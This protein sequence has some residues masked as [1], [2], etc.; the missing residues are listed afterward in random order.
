MESYKHL[1]GLK[2]RCS[3]VDTL[4]NF[5]SEYSLEEHGEDGQ[6][7]E[8][9]IRSPLLVLTHYLE[10]HR[11][12]LKAFVSNLKNEPFLGVP[13]EEIEVLTLA[14]HN[15]E[16][17]YL[18]CGLHKWLI[19]LLIKRLDGKAL[20]RLDKA[21]ALDVE[22]AELLVLGG[23]EAIRDS[24]LPDTTAGRYDKVEAHMERACSDSRV[25]DTG[26]VSLQEL[27]GKTVDLAL[28]LEPIT[29]PLNHQ[30]AVSMCGILPKDYNNLDKLIIRLPDEPVSDFELEV[31]PD[32]RSADS[33]RCPMDDI[34]SDVWL[35]EMILL[36]NTRLTRVL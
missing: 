10:H 36:N 1:F 16:A 15:H 19:R 12:S 25:N 32:N 13:N 22:Y 28:V 35:N 17:A 6:L 34:D 23:I 11:S 31:G 5:L 30:T 27:P 9:E 24:I 26:Y 33:E 14:K 21:H 2:R 4:A 7:V 8:T 20:T 3:I 18:L 29:P